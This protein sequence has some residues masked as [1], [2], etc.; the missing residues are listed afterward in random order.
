MCRGGQ[1]SSPWRAG[2]MGVPGRGWV[3]EMIRIRSPGSACQE[4][5]VPGLPWAGRLPHPDVG[6]ALSS[7][8]PTALGG[9]SLFLLSVQSHQNMEVTGSL[10]MEQHTKSEL[11]MNLGQPQ[12]KLTELK[13]LVEEKYQEAQEL[14]QQRDQY[15]SH[16]QQ[17][18]A[19]YQ[20]LMAAYQQLAN[21]KDVLQK[22]VLLNTQ[23]VNWMQHE[24]QGKMEVELARQELLETQVG[25]LECQTPYGHPSRK[26]CEQHPF[27]L[28]PAGPTESP[29]SDWRK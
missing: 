23:L 9:I 25:Q 26:T 10:Q 2:D 17:Y 24:E 3:Q 1:C 12:E 21:E 13:E 6:G 5:K 8:S 11:A 27:S 16:L 19:T 4:G 7:G 22:Q 14:Q 28:F 20:Q 18:M 29:G 15:F